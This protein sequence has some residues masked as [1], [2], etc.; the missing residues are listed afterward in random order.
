V[1][2]SKVDMLVLCEIESEYEGTDIGSE[3]AGAE[4]LTR[5]QRRRKTRS[6]TNHDSP[7]TDHFPFEKISSLRLL[8]D[9]SD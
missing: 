4:T 5:L 6:M 1:R 8:I 7:C 9:K 3:T 2:A